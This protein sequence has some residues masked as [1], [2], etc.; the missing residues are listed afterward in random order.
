VTLLPRLAPAILPILIACNKV[1]Y[2]VRF[3]WYF[4]T[5][6]LATADQAFTNAKAAG[7]V[8]GMTTALQYRALE[9]NTGAVGLASVKCTSITAKNPEIAAIQQHQDPASSGA[10]ATNKAIVLELAK[11][12]ASIGG[13][14]QDALA[15]G[16]FAPGTIGDPTAKGNTCDDAN[17]ANGC[18]NTLN[19]LV[20]DATAEEINAVSWKRSHNSAS[21]W[22][23]PS[24]CGRNI[25]FWIYWK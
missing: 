7:N 21:F 10:A 3:T 23:F 14:P 2:C 13:N 24:G 22:R 5:A 18:I 1:R 19:L 25:L 6:S 15:T 8:A 16:T 20:P 4:L 11:Q 17:D 12:I 9:R